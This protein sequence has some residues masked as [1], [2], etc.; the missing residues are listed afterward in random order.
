[1][2]SSEKKEL[3]GSRLLA[4]GEAGI[5]TSRNCPVRLRRNK[6]STCSKANMAPTCQPDGLLNGY[7]HDR[8]NDLLFSTVSHDEGYVG[9]AARSS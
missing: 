8:F 1:L 9:R 5:T 7:G 4:D 6:A 2:K 3:E